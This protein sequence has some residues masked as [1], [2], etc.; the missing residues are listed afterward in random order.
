MTVIF[1]PESTSFLTGNFPVT[2]HGMLNREFDLGLG[3]DKVTSWVVLQTMTGT[4]FQVVWNSHLFIY[5]FIR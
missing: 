2:L 3:S 1:V 4:G 5:L